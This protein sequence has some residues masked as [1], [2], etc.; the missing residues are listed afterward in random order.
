MTTYNLILTEQFD[1]SLSNIADIRI[2]KQ[3]WAKLKEL[4]Q[5]CPLGKKLKGNPYWSIRVNK[6]RIIY[7]MENET[8]III[9]ILKRKKDYGEV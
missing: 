6:Y 4:K 7:K 5:R 1:K 8:L 2:N 9:D 3:I